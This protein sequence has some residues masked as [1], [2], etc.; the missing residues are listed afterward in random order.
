[1]LAALDEVIARHALPADVPVLLL[2]G[3]GYIAT[4]VRELAACR[5]VSSIDVGE[6]QQFR[7]LVRQRRGHPLVVINLSKSGVLADYV[8]YF[9]PQ[10]I[11]LNEVYPEPSRHELRALASLGVAAYHIAGVKACCWPQFPRAYR[12]GIPCCASLPLAED[13]HIDVVL[14]RLSSR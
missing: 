11:L 1:V 10:L 5:N 7:A 13:E 8:E 12:G 4:A 14:T 6:R 9:W 3:R 2:G